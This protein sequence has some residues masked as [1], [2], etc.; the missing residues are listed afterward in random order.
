MKASVAINII[1]DSW[2][3]GI[4]PKVQ[5]AEKALSG[6]DPSANGGQDFLRQKNKVVVLKGAAGRIGNL[7]DAVNHLVTQVGDP[8]VPLSRTK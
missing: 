8:E 5:A 1:C 3:A 2:I 4:Q 6:I 7:R